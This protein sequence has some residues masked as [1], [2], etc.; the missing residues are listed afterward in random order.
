MMATAFCT[1]FALVWI[2]TAAMPMAFL[3]RDYPSLD[4]QA[5]D[6]D[7]LSTGFGIV[8]RR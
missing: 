6:L 4:R 2:Y 1:I 3:S 5:D 8:F 7:E